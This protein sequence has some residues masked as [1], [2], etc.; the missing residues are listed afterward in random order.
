MTYFGYTLMGHEDAFKSSRISSDPPAKQQQQKEDKVETEKSSPPPV[1]LPPLANN[2]VVLDRFT[3]YADPRTG[4]C[5]SVAKHEAFRRKHYRYPDQDPP[6]LYRA[7]V[8]ESQRYGWHVAGKD[9]ARAYP[10]A[11]QPRRRYQSSEMTKFV[12]KM[13]L[14]NR[15]FTMC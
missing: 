5:G 10:W 6:Q 3:Y 4:N 12:E 1:K 15:E 11:E 13:T 7:P 2:A 9:L 14:T 8:L